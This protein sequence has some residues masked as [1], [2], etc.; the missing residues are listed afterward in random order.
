MNKQTL[1][2]G[3]KKYPNKIYFIQVVAIGIIILF[4]S[5]CNL[6]GPGLR[7]IKFKSGIDSVAKKYENQLKPKRFVVAPGYTMIGN[8][9]TH[10]IIVTVYNSWKIPKSDEKREELAREIAKDVYKQVINKNDYSEIEVVFK[11]EKGIIIR[12]K[13][14]FDYR[15]LYDEIETDSVNK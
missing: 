14:S 4:V 5:S 8:E 12:F 15:F 7:E 10:R 6:P 1:K 9:T 13:T 3:R 2:M 11:N